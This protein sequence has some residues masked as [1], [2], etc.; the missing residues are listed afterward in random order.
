MKSVEE[1]VFPKDTA[2][3]GEGHGVLCDVFVV[4]CEVVWR[5]D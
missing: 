2:G 1:G 3:A 5:L 4:R